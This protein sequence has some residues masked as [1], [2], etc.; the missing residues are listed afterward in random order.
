V[1][2]RAELWVAALPSLLA[3]AEAAGP[4]WMSATEHARLG[5]MRSVKRRRQFL[6]GHWM[7]RRLA[8]DSFGGFSADYLLEASDK[9]APR[10]RVPRTGAE[11]AA[12]IS[13]SG[14]WIAVA[15]APFDIGV[16]IESA[17]K[18]R[19]WLSLA[20]AAFPATEVEALRRIPEQELACA[21]ARQWTVREAVGKREGHGLRLENSRHQLAV[22]CEAERAE[23]LCWQSGC[24]SLALAGGPGLLARLSGFPDDARAIGYRIESTG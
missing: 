15:L 19:D 24:L 7:I 18:A 5:A 16:D 2:P 3:E 10:L 11:H 17:G 13:H 14:D 9:G 1:G 8:A 12:S 6:A 23:V 4:G 21:F 22:A 20:A